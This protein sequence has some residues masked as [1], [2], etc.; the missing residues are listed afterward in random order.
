MKKILCVVCFLFAATAFTQAQNA[1][2]TSLVIEP[3]YPSFNY[4]TI[5]GNGISSTPIFGEFN[6]RWETC[7]PCGVN[8][9]IGLSVNRTSSSGIGP[10]WINGTTDLVIDGTTYNFATGTLEMIY[11]VPAAKILKADNR[12]KSLWFSRQ[13]V[14]DMHIKLWR[15]G[16]DYP[17]APPIFEQTLQMNCM[18]YLNVS[19]YRRTENTWLHDT[20]SYKWQCTAID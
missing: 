13:G 14:A 9:E 20:Q 17:N 12:K 8:T 15:N 2:I 6:P 7:R 5:G 4:V 16:N 18:A 3:V 10:I 11:D 19:R 1:K